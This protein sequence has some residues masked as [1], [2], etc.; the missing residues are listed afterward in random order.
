MYIILAKV[1]DYQPCSAFSMPA[2][3]CQ[4]NAGPP[5]IWKAQLLSRNFLIFEN[6]LIDPYVISRSDILLGL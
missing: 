3:I 4:N 6:E 1:A 5:I 2:F